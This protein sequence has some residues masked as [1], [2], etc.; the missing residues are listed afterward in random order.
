MRFTS[1]WA[2]AACVLLAACDGAGARSLASGADS[3]YIG[4]AA[5]VTPANVGRFNAVQ[6]AVETLNARGPAVPFAVRL[7]IG[8]QSSQVAVA[9]AFR[10]DPAVVG[11]VGHT[12]SAQTL[13]AAPIYADAEGEGRRALVAVSPTATNP[14]VTRA[15]DWVFRVCPTDE[16]GA[17]ALARFAVDSL[18]AR[19]IAVVFRNDLFG[20]GFTRVFADAATGM[21]ATVLERDPYLS[22]ATELEAYAGRIAAR[23]ADALIIA[24]G[25]PE[26]A[27]IV[28]RVRDA[29]GT[30]AVLGSDDLAN[31]TPEDSRILEGTRYTAF[32]LAEKAT[33]PQAREFAAAYRK[34]FGSE[35]NHVVALTYDAAMLIGAAVRA[36]GADRVRVRDWISRVGRGT[37]PFPG[38]TGA[39]RF[40]EEGDVVDKP[41]LI[42]SIRP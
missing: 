19:R 17:R 10:D 23:R 3:V 9:A 40:D 4:I 28:R 30:P 31:A 21:G 26:A 12:G 42:G 20:R 25:A 39:I 29:G 15:N 37:Q 27:E 24:G 2:T 1:A 8:D 5:A 38:V 22:G 13:E 36:E 18:G 41:V 34:R 16:D 32:Y 33:S 6:L 7:P 35:P 14:A 11:V